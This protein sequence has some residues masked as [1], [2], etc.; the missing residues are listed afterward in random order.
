MHNLKWRWFLSWLLICV[1]IDVVY[2]LSTRHVATVPWLFGL[3]GIILL[4][5]VLY[6]RVIVQRMPRKDHHL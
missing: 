5:L 6:F 4:E 3:L 2:D 1:G